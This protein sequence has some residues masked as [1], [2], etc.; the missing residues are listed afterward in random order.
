[1][2]LILTDKSRETNFIKQGY[3]CTLIKTTTMGAG[4]GIEPRG[5]DS[6]IITKELSIKDNGFKTCKME[7]VKSTGLTEPTLED[8]L[9]KELKNQANS[10][11]PIALPTKASLQTTNSKGKESLF[12]KTGKSIKEIGE[13]I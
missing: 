10:N 11:G 1:M 13:I 2:A 5:M 3:T 9:V 12:G 7:Q 8:I 6:F 4:S